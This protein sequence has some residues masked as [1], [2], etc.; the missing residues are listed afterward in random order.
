MPERGCAMRKHPTVYR[1]LA[2]ILHEEIVY[3]N[4]QVGGRGR[5]GAATNPLET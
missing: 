1:K 4:S 3:R 2:Q 5:G